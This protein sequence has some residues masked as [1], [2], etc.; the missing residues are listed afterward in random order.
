MRKRKEEFLSNRF[1]AIS[2]V[3]VLLDGVDSDQWDFT[4]LCRMFVDTVGYLSCWIA[5]VYES[6]EM[7]KL[8]IYKKD[9]LFLKTERLSD[10]AISDYVKEI[11]VHTSDYITNRDPMLD[12][13]RRNTSGDET[14]VYSITFKLTYNNI[15]Y[16][17]LSILLYGDYQ[18]IREEVLI[19]SDAVRTISVFL[20]EI[21]VRDKIKDIFVTMFETTGNGTALFEED[22]T[23]SYVN[24]EFEKLSGYSKKEIEGTMSW[25]E[26]VVQ[27]DLE[28]MIE[29]HRQRRINHGSAPRNYEFR[30]K[31]RHGAIKNIYMTIDMVPRTKISIA[32]FMNITEKKQLESEILRVS[33]QERQQIGSDLHDGLSPHLVGVKLLLKVMRQKLEKKESPSE[34]ELDEIDTLITDAIDQARRLIKGLKPVD[35]QPDGLI[36]ALEELVNTTCVRY[37]LY[38][39]LECREPVSIKSNITATHLYYIVREA[40]NNSVKHA[41]AKRI[42]VVVKNRNRELSVEIRDDGIGMP[43]ML[44][45]GRGMGL[46]IMRYRA[47]II[48]GDISFERGPRGGTSVLC[49][50]QT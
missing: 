28:R 46:N 37:G 10:L 7:R 40:I 19:L 42:D 45:S 20:Y 3:P 4:T 11:L 6:G 15:I 35:I 38:C 48:N 21:D 2:R 5:L 23:I 24:K 14:P 33:E 39:H 17:V 9:E 41:S 31:D 25:T 50:V 1:K 32:S 26:F 36:F 27:E 34:G 22:T 29:Y 8:S 16:G 30:F 43:D 13:V 44:D 12:Y 18:S 49:I 47:S